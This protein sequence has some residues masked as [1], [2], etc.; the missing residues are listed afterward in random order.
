MGGLPDNS[1]GIFR[2]KKD[3]KSIIKYPGSKWRLAP[4]IISHFPKHHSYLEPFFGSGAVLF[5]KP[6]SDIETINDL[7][8]DVVNLFECIRRDPE[9]LAREI[10]LTPYARE[11]FEKEFEGEPEDPFEKARNFYIR[12]NQGHGYRTTGEK[13]GWKND[14]HGREKAYA[15]REWN[16]LPGKIMEAAERLKNVQIEHMDAIELIRRFRHDDVLIYCD[17]PYVLQTRN[18]KQYRCEME[19]WQHEELLDV[20]IDHP[21]P[22]VLSGYD[23]PLYEERLKKWHKESRTSYNQISG[24]RIETIWMNF[25]PETG[26]QMTLS[27]LCQK[28]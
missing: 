8:G 17:P 22:V 4:W 21:G 28:Q 24:K 25:H 6:S 15:V 13:V 23:S 5:N 26:R 18:R 16:L 14:V 7:D 27:D 9:K 2:P 11:I 12:L 10:H 3:L 19:D 20:L 1:S